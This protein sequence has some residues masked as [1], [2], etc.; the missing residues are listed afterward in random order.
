MVCRQA[1]RELNTVARNFVTAT[2]LPVVLANL[3]DLLEAVVCVK[4]SQD[5][6]SIRQAKGCIH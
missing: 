6:Y 3:G 5:M 1:L 4:L 2:K